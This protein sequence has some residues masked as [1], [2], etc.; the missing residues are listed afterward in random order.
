MTLKVNNTSPIIKNDEKVSKINL[1]LSPMPEN[2]F[3]LVS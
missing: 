2:S 3:F 1:L